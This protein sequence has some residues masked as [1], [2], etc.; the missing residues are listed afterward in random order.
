MHSNLKLNQQ[1]LS[2][3]VLV[4]EVRPDPQNYSGYL[5]ILTKQTKIVLLVLLSH[6]AFLIEA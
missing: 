3:E 1:Y 2:S 5:H 6:T 4:S